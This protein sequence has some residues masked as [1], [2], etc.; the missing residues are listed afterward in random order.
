MG[1]I[2]EENGLY[3]SYD[4]TRYPSSGFSL[5]SDMTILYPGNDDK[6]IYLIASPVSYDGNTSRWVITKESIRKAFDVDLSSSGVISI[7][8]G[9]SS[10]GLTDSIVS[11]IESWEREYSQIRITNGTVVRVEPRFAPFST[12]PH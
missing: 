12:W 2:Y 6:D 9:Y 5:S 4:M 10:Y 8:R 11:Q 7:L 1:I 3:T